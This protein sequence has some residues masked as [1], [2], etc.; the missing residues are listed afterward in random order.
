M[1][2]QETD[3]RRILKQ[4][5]LRPKKGLGQNFI[6][7]R[8]AVERIVQ[9]AELRPD[10]AV[11]EIG[12]GL[13]TLTR[14]LL[15]LAGEVVAVELDPDMVR[16]LQAL[17]GEHPRLRLI[18]GDILRIDPATL[19]PREESRQAIPTYKV[20]ANVPY[21]ITSAILRHLLEASLKPALLVLTVQLEVAQRIVSTD[22]LSLLAVSIQFY[23]RP[24]IVARIPAGAFYPPPKVD[25]A[26]VK[27][28]VYPRP[29]VEVEDVDGFFEVVKAGFSAPRKQLR[30]A[31]AHGLRRPVEEIVR[32][33][34]RAG[35]DPRRRA[36]TIS[37]EEWAGIQRTLEEV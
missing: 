30:N 27:I 17:L 11:L 28:E 7:D 8:H 14:R 37:L 26:V 15:E 29:A 12:P 24:R 20:V 5:G 18:A 32:A 34:E 4:F 13:G 25:S 1:I 16:V 10:D 6:V 36:E 23:G 2:T 9:A 31:L 21:Y 19:F 3:P 22:R 35:I 33:L